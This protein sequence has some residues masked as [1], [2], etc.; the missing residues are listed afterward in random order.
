MT[1][2]GANTKL[3]AVATDVLR[4][5]GR[6]MFAALIEGERDPDAWLTSRV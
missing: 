5:S 4:A 3:A 6:A 1:L 2:E